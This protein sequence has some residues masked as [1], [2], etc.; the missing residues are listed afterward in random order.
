[1]Q[2]FQFLKKS[3]RL[4]ILACG[5]TETNN[6]LSASTLAESQ[7]FFSSFGVPKAQKSVF[8]YM[9]VCIA[10]LYAALERKPL[11]SFP[12]NSLQTVLPTTASG[13]FMCLS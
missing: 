6:G 9:S 1:M 2:S 5:C 11:N 4:K 3:L 12:T 7:T 8:N 13:P 10:Y